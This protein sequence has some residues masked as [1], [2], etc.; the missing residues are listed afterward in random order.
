[1]DFKGLS[2]EGAGRMPL[3]LTHKEGLVAQ[4]K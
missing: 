4:L 3:I 2:S 1:M